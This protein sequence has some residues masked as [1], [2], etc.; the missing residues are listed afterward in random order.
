MFISIARMHHI[1]N[2]TKL[3]RLKQFAVTASVSGFVK[4][5]RPGVLVFDGKKDCIK[6]FLENARS[7]RYLDF[8]HVHTIPLNTELRIA[9]SQV[10]LC[11]VQD[12]TALIQALDRLDL[13]HWFR[14]QMGMDKG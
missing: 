10:G 11:E 6:A 5:G 13:K 9:G 14:V 4:T 12:M 7:L 3:R 1:R 2:I 8:H